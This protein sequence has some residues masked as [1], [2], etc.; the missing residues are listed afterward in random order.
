MKEKKYIH[1]K[2]THQS[3]FLTQL[4]YVAGVLLRA[5]EREQRVGGQKHHA[6][7]TQLLS[8]LSLKETGFR[9]Q[10]QRDTCGQIPHS[11]R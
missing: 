9:L 3:G 7:Q 4:Y 6:Y 1:R 2:V 5:K 10:K 11:E 8:T